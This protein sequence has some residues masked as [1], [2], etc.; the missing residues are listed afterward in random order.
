ML[1]KWKNTLDKDKYVRAVFMNL[2]KLFDT[3]KHDFLIAKLEPY[4]FSNNVLIFMLSYFKNRSQRVSINNS[5]STWE[6]I[7]A[8]APEGSILWPLPFNIFLNDIFYF[9]N[10]AFLSNY[11]DSNFLYAFGSNLEEVKQNLIQDLLKLL[12]RFHGNCM[13]LNSEER[14][15]IALEKILKVISWNFFGEVLEA[16]KLET[17]LGMQLKTN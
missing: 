8:G 14:H 10:R 13:I 16:S 2:S 17:V 3:I 12:E 1:E 9:E 7:I 15:Y 11:T 4:E 5:F 6:E